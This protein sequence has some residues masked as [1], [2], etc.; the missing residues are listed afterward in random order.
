MSTQNRKH[1]KHGDKNKDTQALDC[2]QERNRQGDMSD[3]GDR[4]GTRIMETKVTK[5]ETWN[6]GKAQ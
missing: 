1:D 3:W 5:Q 4:K 6:T 2:D